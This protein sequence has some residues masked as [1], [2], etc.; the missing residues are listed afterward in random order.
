M[1][2]FSALFLAALALLCLLAPTARATYGVDISSQCEDDCFSCLV[3]SGYNY[4]I[5]RGWLSYGAPDTNCPHTIY[6]AWAG[7][8]SD[9]DVYL[10]PCAGSDGPTQMSGMINYIAGYQAT[11]GQIWLDIETN[12]SSGCGWS[13]D[14][15]SNCAYIQSLI[16]SGQSAGKTVGVYASAYMWNTIAGSSCTVG[17]DLGAPLWYADY[18]GE[19]NFNNFSPFGGWSSPAMKQYNTG[20]ECGVGVDL[21]WY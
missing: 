19:A 10:F 20:T 1:N 6:N 9:V 17:A 16:Q 4:V 15:G 11:Y 13:G 14:Q 2:R 5:I 12:P 3:S 8:M 18:D 21:N 7:G